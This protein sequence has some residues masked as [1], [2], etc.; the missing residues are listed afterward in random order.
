MPCEPFEFAV[1]LAALRPNQPTF[2]RLGERELALVRLSDGS[3]HCVAN[4]C[5]H[6]GG[7]LAA[8]HV[9][10]TVLV[11]P[12]HAWRFDVTTGRCPD[13]PARCVARYPVRVVGNRVEVG[14]DAIPPQLPPA[15]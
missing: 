14:L 4:R 3:V 7:N 12:V 11:C 6:A 9:E 1:N 13:A 15:S 10:G 8:G 2:V 5:P